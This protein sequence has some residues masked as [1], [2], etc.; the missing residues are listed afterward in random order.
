MTAPLFFGTKQPDTAKC[1][2]KLIKTE[3]DLN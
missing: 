3:P 2:V 1:F